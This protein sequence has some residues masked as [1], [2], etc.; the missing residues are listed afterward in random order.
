MPTPRVAPLPLIGGPRDGTTRRV[1]NRWALYLNAAGEPMDP[2]TGDRFMTGR[3][4]QSGV[5]ALRRTPGGRPRDYYW[6]SR[7]TAVAS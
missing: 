2:E 5:Y 6:F 3:G 7:Q 4:R 1:A